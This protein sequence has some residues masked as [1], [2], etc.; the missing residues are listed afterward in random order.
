M[1]QTPEEQGSATAREV[2]RE[3]RLV[4]IEMKLDSLHMRF[5]EIRDDARALGLRIAALEQDKHKR[6]GAMAAIGALCG[7]LGAFL[8]K[9][10]G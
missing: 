5:D 7:L 6:T 8:S 10:W 1:T 9:F 4:R 3:N 2:S